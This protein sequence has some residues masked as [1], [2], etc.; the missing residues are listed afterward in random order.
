[1]LTIYT[2]EQRRSC[3]LILAGVVTLA[4]VWETVY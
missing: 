4:A 2:P 3:R 1:M